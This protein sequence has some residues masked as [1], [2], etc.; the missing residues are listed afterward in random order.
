[1]AESPVLLL[2]GLVLAGAVALAL[3]RLRAD[4]RRLRRRIDAATTELQHLQLSF[5][6]FAPNAVVESIAARARIPEAERREVTVLFAD[7]VGFTALSEQLDPDVLVAVLNEYFVRMSRVIGEHRGHVAKFIGDGL[8]ALFGALEPNPW[9]VNDAVHAALAMQRA[10]VAYNAELASRGLPALRAGIGI[11]RGT[12]VA[13]L[14]GSDA[15]MEFTVIGRPVNLASRVEG[16]TR[17]HHVDILVTAAVRDRLDPRFV[18]DELPAREVRGVAE[19]VVTYAVRG[20]REEGDQSLSRT[21][22]GTGRA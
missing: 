13:G 9:Q 10:L 15:L 2:A 16:L 7:L 14:I 18:L 4:R 8:M 1:M 22:T 17:T 3:H 11:H 19:P 20:F 12:A 21:G 6:R 5:A